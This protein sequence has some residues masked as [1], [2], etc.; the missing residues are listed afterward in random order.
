MGYLTRDVLNIAE[1]DRFVSDDGAG[2]VVT[3]IGTTRYRHGGRDVERLEYEA[4]EAIAEAMLDD[5]CREARLKFGL[6]HVHLQHRLGTVDIGEASVAIAV[7][8]AHR[9]VAFDACRWLID[10][11]KN[12]VPIFKKEYYADGSAPNW[13]GPD[14]LPVRA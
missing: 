7:S 2:A 12:T 1:L 8:A 10:S 9:G 3:F 11:L 6:L 4:Q 14:G 5:L 13:V